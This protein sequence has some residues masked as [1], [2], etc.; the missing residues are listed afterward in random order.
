MALVDD[1]SRVIVRATIGK[2]LNARQLLGFYQYNGAYFTGLY[3]VKAGEA[4][5]DNTEVLRWFD[6]AAVMAER[7]KS[8]SINA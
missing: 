4:A 2:G 6:V 5:I 7:L 3:V 1:K 8:S